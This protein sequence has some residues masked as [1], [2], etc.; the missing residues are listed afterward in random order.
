[1]ALVNQSEFARMF[2][3]AKQTVNGW[4]RTGRILIDDAGLIDVE[5]A[6]RRLAATASPMLHHEANRQ[7]YAERRQA[8]PAMLAAAKQRAEAMEQ[9]ADRLGRCEGSL[10]A[11]VVAEVPKLA[12]GMDR[13]GR[14]AWEQSGNDGRH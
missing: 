2:G 6:R 4:V 3:F 14:E 12:G 8:A 5:A 7:K 10:G 9:F 11:M 1:M 13:L